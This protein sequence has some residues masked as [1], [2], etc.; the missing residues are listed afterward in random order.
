[1]WYSLIL[2]ISSWDFGTYLISVQQRLRWDCSSWHP[3]ASPPLPCLHIQCRDMPGWKPNFRLLVPLESCV[4]M[5]SSPPGKFFMLFC[6]LL[7]FFKINFFWKILSG[8]PPE[9]Q[10]DWI[11]IRPDILSDLIWVQ[12]VCKCYQQTTL[13]G[14][15]SNIFDKYQNLWNLLNSPFQNPR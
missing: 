6:R 2:S 13:G 3:R 1:M 14:K 8:I 7:F 4:C 15:E 11:K 10:T 5:N 9:C 12:S